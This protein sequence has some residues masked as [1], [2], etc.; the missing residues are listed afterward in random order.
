MENWV[1]AKIASFCS[2]S[3]ITKRSA[4]SQTVKKVCGL[5]MVKKC[6]IKGGGPVFT[7]LSSTVL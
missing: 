7:H 1:F 2:G 3:Q 4:I 5:K 6:E